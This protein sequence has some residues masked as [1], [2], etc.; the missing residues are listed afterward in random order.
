MNI[1]EIAE[2]SGVSLRSVRKLEKLGV[3]KVGAVDPMID[4][5]VYM[6]GKSQQ[7]PVDALAALVEAPDMM[8]E[9]GRYSG[10]AEF[11]VSSLGKVE[12]DKAPGDVAAEIDSAA[13]GDDAAI[14]KIADWLKTVI[15]TDCAVGH[16][17]VAVR[18]LL[19][20][21]LSVRKH[22]YSRLARALLNVR[23]HPGFAGWSS[24]TQEGRHKLSQYH[25]PA[26]NFDL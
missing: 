8:Q 20:A 9:L 3:L 1:Y 18:L 14:A 4:K 26:E 5:I 24:Y 21:P 13:K 23:R 16:H 6:L 19:G 25:R 12:R 7:L 2:K 22:S 15:P 11:Q 17:F 10:E